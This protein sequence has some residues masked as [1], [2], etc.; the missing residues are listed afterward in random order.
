MPTA[1]ATTTMK[2]AQ[3]SSPGAAFEIVEREI[4]EPGAGHVRI[5]VQACGVCHSDVL[6]KDG[7]WPG[8]QYPR[9]PGHEVAGIIDDVGAGVSAWKK[10]QRVGVGWHGGQ[11]NTCRECRRGD[12][13][14]CRNVK[15]CGISYDGGYQQYMIAP[16]E[17]LVP[18][19]KS[20][21]DV[22]A[23]PLLCAGIT[24]YNALR[25]SGAMPGDVVAVLGIG[26]LGH[27]GIQF[28]NKFGY[29]VVAIGRG[30]ENGALAKKL[31][32]NQYIDSQSTNAAQTLQ[33]LGGAQVILATAPSSKAMSELVD[34]LAPNG[35]LMV[36]GATFDAIEVTP[37]QLITGSRSIQG[38]VAGTP[39]DSEDTLHFAEL[40]GVRP[41]I[42]TYPLERAD[43]AYARMLSGKAEFRV[44]LTM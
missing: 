43:E 29:N 5:K 35:K 26:G 27:L 18:I 14:H 19:P 34:G 11:D 42:E 24:T 8:I 40:T 7:L 36:I 22:D 17:A 44:V 28:A 32:A 31:G 2:V 25:H 13:R 10:G 12:F 41:M 30:S 6:T 39:A 21:S 38:W 9:V 1:V 16:V 33:E 37:V 20:L 4:P 15:I 23:A 3:V